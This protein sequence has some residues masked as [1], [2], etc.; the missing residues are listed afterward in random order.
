[1]IT[2]GDVLKIHDFANDQG[3]SF[4]GHGPCYV[5]FRKGVVH[6]CTQFYHFEKIEQVL[7]KNEK[8]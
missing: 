2:K 1:L 7:L 4:F 6:Y 8:K 3:Y 5:L